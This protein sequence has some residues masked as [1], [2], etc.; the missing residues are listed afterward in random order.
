[1]GVSPA[2]KVTV[3]GFI[4]AIVPAPAPMY[5]FAVKLNVNV[6]AGVGMSAD[7]LKTFV[8]AAFAWLVESV[9]DEYVSANAVAGP[10][11]SAITNAMLATRD[12]NVF[13]ILV[14]IGPPF[15][16]LFTVFFYIC[17]GAFA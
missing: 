10:R 8:T 15:F 4:E 14:M 1:M 6:A 12:K 3:V 2:V 5:S 11:Q 7:I 13:L 17:T 9:P 16:L